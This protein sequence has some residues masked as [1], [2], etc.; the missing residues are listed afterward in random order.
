MNNEQAMIEALEARSTR[1]N[2]RRE[3]MRTVSGATVALA[4]ASLLSACGGDDDSDRPAPPARLLRLR[5]RPV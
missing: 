5:L 3:F 4:G 2:E 1:R